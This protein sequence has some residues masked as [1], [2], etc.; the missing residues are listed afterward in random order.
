MNLGPVYS[1]IREDEKLSLEALR[2]RDHE[3]TEIDVRDRQF[4]LDRRSTAFD[5]IE[6]RAGEV[7]A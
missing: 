3:V 1:R 5:W 4:A 2:E 6:R 7:A